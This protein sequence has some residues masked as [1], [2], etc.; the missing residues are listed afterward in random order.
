M[1]GV[2]TRINQQVRDVE[3]RIE[4]LRRYLQQ[5]FEK[6]LKEAM[7]NFDRTVIGVLGEMKDELLQGVGRIEGIEQ[8]VARRG[9]VDDLLTA[10]SEQ[11]RRLLGQQAEAHPAWPDLD[12]GGEGDSESQT[13]SEAPVEAVPPPTAEPDPPC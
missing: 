11:A 13:E 10:R 5:V 6:D 9:H 3:T 1:A 2:E 4:D 7:V 12:D 8:A